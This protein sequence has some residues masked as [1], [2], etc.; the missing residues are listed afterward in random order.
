MK[1]VNALK[2][3]IMYMEYKEIVVCIDYHK[4]S[5]TSKYKEKSILLIKSLEQI[6]SIH[7]ENNHI[8]DTGMLVFTKFKN[9][10]TVHLW[11]RL[12]GLDKFSVSELISLSYFVIINL[13]GESKDLLRVIPMN[14]IKYKRC[15]I[16][17]LF[18]LKNRIENEMYCFDHLILFQELLLEIMTLDSTK[19]SSIQIDKWKD[20][21]KGRYSLNKWLS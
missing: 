14:E 3:I 1:S 6:F 11:M 10:T 17:I 13:L 15:A 18:E 7:F 8:I 19:V 4:R 9:F 5:T 12:L 16:L 2:S 21:V 20:I